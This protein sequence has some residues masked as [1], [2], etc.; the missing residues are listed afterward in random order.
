METDETINTTT[1]D[2]GHNE[3]LKDIA[4][5]TEPEPAS[6]QRRDET[7]DTTLRLDE[8]Q[9]QPQIA[10][11]DREPVAA[12]QDA[13]PQQAAIAE[14]SDAKSPGWWPEGQEFSADALIKTP[15]AEIQTAILHRLEGWIAAWELQDEQNYL[16]YYSVDF[17]PSENMDRTEWIKQRRESLLRPEWIRLNIENMQME[18][19]NDETV[20]VRFEQIYRSNLFS[21]QVLKELKLTREDKQWK[22][23][24]ENFSALETL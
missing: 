24:E 5:K 15:P 19:L 17:M 21:D 11:V 4:A 6:R 9:V 12:V 22:I 8:N 10:S 1:E 7:A 2:S 16:G 18:Q 23:L 3:D 20:R 13:Q 14:V